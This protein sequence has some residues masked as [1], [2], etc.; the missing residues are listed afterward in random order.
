MFSGMSHDRW[1]SVK[2][3]LSLVTKELSA[4]VDDREAK[5]QGLKAFVETR[6]AE[7]YQPGA[8][9]SVLSVGGEYSVLL[10]H[11]I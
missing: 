10:L 5:T 11:Y 7:A 2:V 6:V 9:T 8:K 1:H 4:Q 3:S